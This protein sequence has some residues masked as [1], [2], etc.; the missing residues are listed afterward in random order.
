MFSTILV[1]NKNIDTL[2]MLIYF[3]F[4][5]ASVY[6]NGSWSSVW[7]I[8]FKY[9]QQTVEVKGKTQVIL[10]RYLCINFE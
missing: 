4:S 6:S 3:N 8:E 5:L 1:P 2:I 10:Y 7:N 9:D